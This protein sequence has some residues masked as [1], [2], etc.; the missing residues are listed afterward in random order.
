[1]H[2]RPLAIALS[3]QRALP[4]KLRRS[5]LKRLDPAMLADFPF[6]CD[7][8][9]LRFR[10]NIVNY[11]DRL[12]YF[13]GAHEKYMLHF[14]RDACSAMRA[15]R[16]GGFTFMDVG[17][18][19]GNHT[20]F[21]AQL[22]DH[23]VAFEPFER[24]RSQLEENIRINGLQNVHVFPY[25]LGNEAARLP[26]YAGPESNLGSASFCADHRPENRLLGELEIRR[27]DDVIAAENISRIDILKADVEGYERPVL[28]GL[29][30][31]LKR[32]R[33]LIIIELS[34]K[35]R[36]TMP[37]MAVLSR[38]FPERYKFFSFAHASRDSGRYR[39]QPFIFGGA[40]LLEDV[41]AC[42]EELAKFLP[43]KG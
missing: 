8:Y 6:E 31:T 4:Y 10:G 39:L 3:R 30:A 17:A 42:P 37:S 27:G 19:A 14:L 16:P 41:I 38:R 35:T 24:V 21:M 22:A 12:I 5:L 43:L 34:Q 2:T 40:Q 9:G 29:R 26:F 28:E 18:N 11:I 23:V 36:S 15:A 20:L 13:C 25:G 33:P 1:M 7:F 32:D